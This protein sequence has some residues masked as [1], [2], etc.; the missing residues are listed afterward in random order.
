M[1]TYEQ[2]SGLPAT[3]HVEDVCIILG[4]GMAKNEQRS[5]ISRARLT[6]TRKTLETVMKVRA[7]LD[8]CELAVAITLSNE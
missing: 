8:L 1:E 7:V 6:H 3:D 2:V 4:K 5:A